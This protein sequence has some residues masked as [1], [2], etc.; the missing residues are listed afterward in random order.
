MRAGYI[1]PGAGSLITSENKD[2]TDKGKL[3]E[4]IGRKTTDL[5]NGGWVTEV[6][7]WFRKAYFFE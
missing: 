6:M 7:L 3:F 5:L 2:I 1:V 4:R